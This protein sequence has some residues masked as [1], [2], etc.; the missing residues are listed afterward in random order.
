MGESIL[1]KH[2]DLVNESFELK[3]D[4]FIGISDGKIDYI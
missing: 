1:I 2:V 4:M 3:K